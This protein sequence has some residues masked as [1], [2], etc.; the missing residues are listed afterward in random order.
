M[1]SNRPTYE[2]RDAQWRRGI[3]PQMLHAS[4]QPS[5]PIGS[6]SKSTGVGASHSTLRNWAEFILKSLTVVA[7]TIYV[8]LGLIAMYDIPEVYTSYSS[9]ECVRVVSSNPKHTCKNLPE[10]SETVWVK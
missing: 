6:S 1:N 7:V 5:A 2:S 3:D 10:R 4:S 9:G 8:V